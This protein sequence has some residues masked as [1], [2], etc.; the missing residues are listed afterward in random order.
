[1]MDAIARNGSFASAAR[2]L[3]RVPSALTY[4]VR[5]LEGCLDVLLFDRKSGQARLTAAGQ[6]DLAAGISISG[7]SAPAVEAVE[8]VEAFEDLPFVLSM[9][10]RHPLAQQAAP[11]GDDELV[12]HRAV[13]VSDC[14]SRS[15]PWTGNLLP[16]QDVLT[17]STQHDKLQALL[18]GLGVGFMPEPWIREAVEQD[19]LVPKA[20]RR[21]RAPASSGYAW[22]L[23][24]GTAGAGR[25]LALQWWLE[26]PARPANEL[27]RLTRL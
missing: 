16:G 10:P 26:H 22:R 17:V 7:A 20:V 23:G 19:R 4:G 6:A 24:P 9:S 11:L 3:G 25:R 5:R 2:E 14:A 1:M 8:A 15:P 27:A 18:L 12:R 21:S 13:A